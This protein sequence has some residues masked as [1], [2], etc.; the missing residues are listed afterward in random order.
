MKSVSTKINQSVCVF[1]LMLG[2]MG[3]EEHYSPSSLG[4]FHW[5][6]KS[7]CIIQNMTLRYDL[8]LNGINLTPK[9]LICIIALLVK[10]SR[11]QCPLRN[12]KVNKPDFH[13]ASCQLA[14]SNIWT[15]K[16]KNLR[17]ALFW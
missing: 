15:H 5:L 7:T 13:G 16:V 9:M 2:L 3:L 4:D 8:F 12:K 11:L 10:A 6:F 14:P 1:Q 17:T